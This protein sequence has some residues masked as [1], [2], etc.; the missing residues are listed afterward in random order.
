MGRIWVTGFIALSAVACAGPIAPLTSPLDGGRPWRELRTEHF[1]LQTDTSSGNA[2]VLLQHLETGHFALQ[3][4]A[5][6]YDARLDVE[7]RIVFFEDL[8]DLAQLGFPIAA[9]AAW[10]PSLYFDDSSLLLLSDPGSDLDLQ[11][12]FHELTHRFVAFYYPGAP[13]WLREGLA[14]YYSTVRVQNGEAVLGDYVGDITF[15]QGNNAWAF[16]RAR[17]LLVPISSVPGIGALRAMEPSVFY[18]RFEESVPEERARVANYSGA[19]AMVH[20]LS[21][22]P[23]GPRLFE[24]YLDELYRGNLS[25]TQAWQAAFGQHQATLDTYFR[26]FLRAD[27][28]QR[29]YRPVGEAPEVEPSERAMSPSEVHTLWAIARRAEDA[30]GRTL[31]RRDLERAIAADPSNA[32]AYLRRAMLNDKERRWPDAERDLGLANAAAPGVARY[33][34]ARATFSIGRDDFAKSSAKQRELRRWVRDVTRAPSSTADFVFL[35]DWAVFEGH[36]D[37]ALRYAS[38]GIRLDPSCFYCYGALASAHAAR[39]DWPKAIAALRLAINLFPHGFKG[40]NYV[41]LLE[42]YE[43]AQAEGSIEPI[44]D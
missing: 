8:P 21:S 26:R 10:R 7:T 31:E 17:R 4:A 12:V 29:I 40:P 14:E 25:E 43:Q 5:F 39:A 2:R 41:S 36:I 37:A 34:V 30:S 38:R 23:G 27:H 11:L 3:K 28:F 13:T 20:T 15:T 42:R 9:G 24:S 18:R 1:T 19:W 32:E 22:L 33:L 16:T 6:P 44:R 35:A